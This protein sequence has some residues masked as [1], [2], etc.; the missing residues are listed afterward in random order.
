MVTARY[1]RPTTPFIIW[2]KVLRAGNLSFP[3]RMTET[4]RA[5]FSRTA[6]LESELMAADIRSIISQHPDPAALARVSAN[7]DDN[8]QLRTTC[9]AT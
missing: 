7:P 2:P 8:A 4:T 1:R 5:Y 3:F 6:E 9:V